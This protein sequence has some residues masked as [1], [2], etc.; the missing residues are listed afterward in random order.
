M[1]F[2]IRFFLLVPMYASYNS[3]DGEILKFFVSH[4]RPRT[5]R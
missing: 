1:Q 2:L 3:S 5:R 4:A